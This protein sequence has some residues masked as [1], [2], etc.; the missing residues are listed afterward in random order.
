M[1]ILK[2]LPLQRNVIHEFNLFKLAYNKR[3]QNEGLEAERFQ[4]FA[5][6]YYMIRDI[7]A[8]EKNF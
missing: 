1:F 7:N 4:I 6:N 3:Y 5:K 8:K 2:F